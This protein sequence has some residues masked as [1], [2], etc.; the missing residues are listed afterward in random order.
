[1]ANP[2]HPDSVAPPNMPFGSPFTKSEVL[3]FLAYSLSSC[4]S[5]ID[6]PPSSSNQRYADSQRASPF[7]RFLQRLRNSSGKGGNLF[8]P[9][10]S[11]I[12]FDVSL[13]LIAEL[14]KNIKLALKMR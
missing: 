5:Q 11:F 3:L 7:F 8:L 2:L 12:L 13:P 6:S 4:N 1:M 10:S 14:V 9:S